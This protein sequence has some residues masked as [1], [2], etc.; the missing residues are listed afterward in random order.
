MDDQ[1]KLVSALLGG[2]L[3]GRTKK[4]GFALRL[5]TRMAVGSGQQ[6]SELV[7]E[8]L[9]KLLS[10]GL[11]EQL[12]DQAVQAGKAAVDARLQGLTDTL[13]QR[14]ASLK[15]ASGAAQGTADK[16]TGTV[17]DLLGSSS[18]DEHEPEDDESDEPE[19][20]PQDEAPAKKGRKSKSKPEPEPEPEDE[21]DEPEDEE[22]E[23]EEPE[24][25]EG[26][27]PDE[28]AEGAEEPEP[29]DEA[30]EEEPEEE[31]EPEEDEDDDREQ[32]IEARA[33]QLR[34]KRIDTL[35]KMG[36]DL[37]FSKKDLKEDKPVLADW[38]A[39]AEIE[40][41][42]NDDA[43]DAEDESDEEGEE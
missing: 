15:D 25:D 28:E 8:N 24:E 13:N 31:D 42:D 26:E 37:G 32:R 10:S 2:Y 9:T 39:E 27:E 43:E 11:V 41:E 21:A 29:E 4:G 3:L 33:K 22:P 35:R 40:D 5:A 20:E 18:S 36:E 12:R 6:P 19:E 16:A 34:R 14:T 23:D 30:A 17:S 1:V 7:R 38:I